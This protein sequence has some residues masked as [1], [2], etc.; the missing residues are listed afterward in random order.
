MT[1]RHLSMMLRFARLRC[2][3][4]ASTRKPHAVLSL[5]AE[6][7]HRIV[8]VQE[9]SSRGSQIARQLARP[10]RLCNAHRSGVAVKAKTRRNP[11]S[12]PPKGLQGIW[13]RA[14]RARREATTVCAY[15]RG[16]GKMCLRAGEQPLIRRMNDGPA[17]ERS[18]CSDND[19]FGCKVEGA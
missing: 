12:A 14:D 1:R 6:G 17:D 16:K 2:L 8:L 19:D 13:Q 4:A 18:D 3:R 15:Q 10:E 5:P 11:A 9:P 7:V